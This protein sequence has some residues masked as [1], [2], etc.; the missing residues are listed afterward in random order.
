MGDPH[1]RPLGPVAWSPDGDRLAFWRAAGLSDAEPAGLYTMDLEGWE[2]S[3]LFSTGLEEA[4]LDLA[5]S[6]DGRRIAFVEV[7][8]V[9]P[10]DL[11][12]WTMPTLYTIAADGT[13]LREIQVGRDG[14][15][16][17][18]IAWSPTAR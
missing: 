17:R 5:W 16:I 1:A 9:I 12:G 13:D 18:E 4:V 6:P 11:T 10:G 7:G 2:P 14:A 15:S 3:L 8:P